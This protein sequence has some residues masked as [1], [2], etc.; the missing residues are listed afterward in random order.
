MSDEVDDVTVPAAP[1]R[2]LQERA[3]ALDHSLTATEHALSRD[4]ALVGLTLARAGID[5]DARTLVALRIIEGSLDLAVDPIECLSLM[6]ARGVIERAVAMT[7]D[8]LE[9]AA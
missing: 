4:A 6:Q 3:I 5:F 8:L 1:L 2:H 7:A 9:D